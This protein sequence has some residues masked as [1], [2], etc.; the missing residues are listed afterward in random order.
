MQR[1]R[2]RKRRRSKPFAV[3]IESAAKI[4]HALSTEELASLQFA[5]ESHRHHGL[6]A[7]FQTGTV[8]SVQTAIACVFLPTTALYAMLIRMADRPLVVTS[9]NEDSAPIK[10]RP[11]HGK[12]DAAKCG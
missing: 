12:R 10:F 7:K 5:S 6:D 2:D 4:C 11:V 9:A 3:M 8:C 1:L